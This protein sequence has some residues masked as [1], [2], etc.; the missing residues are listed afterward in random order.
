MA[1]A[2]GIDATLPGV[3]L[4]HSLAAVPYVLIALSPAYTGL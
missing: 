4:A 2:W 3:W 1:L